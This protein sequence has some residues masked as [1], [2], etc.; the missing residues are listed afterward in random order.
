MEVQEGSEVTVRTVF[1]ADCGFLESGF[2]CG[3]GTASE[4]EK[5]LTMM[6]FSRI[7]DSLA[8]RNYDPELFNY[9][10]PCLSAIGSALPPDYALVKSDDDD[11]EANK[12]RTDGRISYQPN[13]PETST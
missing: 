5:R 4:A 9:A 10:L 13:P 12:V 1:V 3:V 6:L 11:L 7:F 2:R 8:G